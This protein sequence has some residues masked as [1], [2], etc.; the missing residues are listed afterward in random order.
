M[1]EPFA[2]PR[3]VS[4]SDGV[5][6]APRLLESKP[7]LAELQAR[8]ILEVLPS[9]ARAYFIIGAARRRLGDPKRARNILELLVKAQP[10]SAYANHE[11]GLALG[12]LAPRHGG[13][14]GLAI[15]RGELG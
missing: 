5:R 9:D 10:N 6:H 11:L 1:G 8:E 13:F 7:E 14:D 4:A 2:S 3:G 12:D 15:P